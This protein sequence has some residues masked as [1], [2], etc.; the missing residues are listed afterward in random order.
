MKKTKTWII[1]CIY[2]QLLFICFGSP[3]GNPVTDAVNDIDKLIGNLPN[4][5][6]MTLK[7]DPMME[8]LPKHCWLYVMVDELSI[9]LDR[10]LH[11]FS[12]SSQNYLI[13]SNLSLIFHGIRNCLRLNEQMDFIEEF[14]LLGAG[15]LN[16]REFFSYVTRT[17]EVF[18][19][20]NNTD[21]DST[22]VLPTTGNPEDG[23]SNRDTNQGFPYVPSNRKN[24]SRIVSSEKPK[25]SSGSSLEW[26]SIALIT[27]CCL[28]VGFIFGVVCWKIKH[29]EPQRETED[30][31]I[32]IELKEDNEFKNMLRQTEN[33]VPLV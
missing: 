30:P 12:N 10:L 20:I 17:I 22:C 9:R 31:V 5:Y 25:S 7:Y 18:K 16:P 4:D 21:Y 13:L 23:F 27:L 1:T 26:T 32:S 3:C 8:A 28:F 14:S 24:S 29:R 33:G 6:I 2:L 15:N 11:K 19:E